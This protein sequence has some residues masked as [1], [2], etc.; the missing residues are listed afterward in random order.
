MELRDEAA[1]PVYERIRRDRQRIPADL[2]AWLD[3]IE[4][5]LFDHCLNVNY[6]KNKAGVRDN[7]DALRFHREVGLSPKKYITECRMTVAATLLTTTQL[8]IFEISD[9]LGFDS[10]GVFSKSF[11]TFHG[12]RPTKFRKKHKVVAEVKSV[13]RLSEAGLKRILEGQATPAEA[14]ALIAR[15]E[16]MYSQWP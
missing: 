12:I 15:L 2:A 4:G 1:A 16:T 10:L 6:I 8:K 11:E 3:V 14:R 13:S 7:S 5:V 9:L